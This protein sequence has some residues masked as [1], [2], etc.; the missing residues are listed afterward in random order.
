MNS[1]VADD[2]VSAVS[3]RLSLTESSVGSVAPKSEAVA[4]TTPAPAPAERRRFL[5]AEDDPLT[6]RMVSA[7]VE[8]EGYRAVPVADGLQA[9]ESLVLDGNVSAAIFDMKMPHLQGLDL[10]IYMKSNERLRRIPVGMITAARDPKVWDDSVAA[11]AC[12]MLAKP[13]TPAQVQMMVRVL[14]KKSA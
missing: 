7:I 14:A 12:V 11:G 5:V 9:L 3:G 2:Q 1:I 6:L 10:I 8:T 4:V 13:F